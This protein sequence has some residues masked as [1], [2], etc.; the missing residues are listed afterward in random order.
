MLATAIAFVL[1]CF[2]LHGKADAET[3][4]F[5][6]ESFD[7]E[8]TVS[9]MAILTDP[10]AKNGA[11]I[12][13]A[14]GTDAVHKITVDG[15]DYHLWARARG[16]KSNSNSFIIHFDRDN[17]G[18]I[19]PLV[20]N[21]DG[22]I[23]DDERYQLGNEVYHYN[24]KPYSGWQWSRLFYGEKITLAKGTYTLTVLPREPK[25]DLDQLIFTTDETYVPEGINDTGVPYIMSPVPGTKLSTSPVEF[26][27]SVGANT[28]RQYYI[29]VG[30]NRSTFVYTP[31]LYQEY[32]PI[33]VQS[34]LVQDLDSK[35]PEIILD[36]KPLYVTLWSY[37]EGDHA[38]FHEQFIYETQEVTPTL[39]KPT[40][41]A[42]LLKTPT[43]RSTITKRTET[44]VW[45]EVEGATWYLLRMTQNENLLKME[46]SGDGDNWNWGYGDGGNGWGDR[47]RRYINAGQYD[48]ALGLEIDHLPLNGRPL[49]VQ[50]WYQVNGEWLYE[51]HAYKTAFDPYLLSPVP[52]GRTTQ[53]DTE[54]VT[55]RW[56]EIPGAVAYGLGVATEQKKLDDAGAD[57]GYGDIFYADFGDTDFRVDLD[58]YEVAVD[59]IPVGQPVYVRLWYS[60]PFHKWHWEDYVFTNPVLVH[61]FT[62]QIDEDLGGVFNALGGFVS[63]DG[64]IVLDDGTPGYVHVEDNRTPDSGASVGQ[65]TPTEE[66]GSEYWYEVLSPVPRG[67]QDPPQKDLTGFT[68]IRFSMRL[69]PSAGEDAIVPVSVKSDN[70]F[71]VQS[72]VFAS[73]Y[74]VGHEGLSTEWREVVIPL[75][76]FTQLGGMGFDK[77]KTTATIQIADQIQI[78]TRAGG[79]LGD[80]IWME[81]R[82][83]D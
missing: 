30:K 82:V 25:S 24:Y 83:S 12:K 59:N 47:Q 16:A 7:P 78:S 2:A 10:T 76:A 51:Q 55:F 50:L 31:E 81:R 1:V 69:L 66:S 22:R 14:K 28:R 11:Y 27:W 41:N 48:P 70:G 80:R 61:D 45:D 40:P 74:V 62:G 71:G 65:L 20:Q 72:T 6:A 38:W 64:S 36:G 77:L 54:T 21:S 49:Y 23:D 4:I 44:F 9:P 53:L 19:K 58:S 56:D 3:R 32:L 73:D 68:D 75:N 35:D 8:E 57:D 17:N 42:R 43:L 5:E 18:S 26:K 79:S 29:G 46:E 37:N 60:T 67:S 63:T 13:S 34:A 52:D 39:P 33:N 15:G